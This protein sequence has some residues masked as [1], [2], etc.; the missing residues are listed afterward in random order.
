MSAIYPLWGLKPP[1]LSDL[2]MSQECQEQKGPAEMK[3]TFLKHIGSIKRPGNGKRPTGT[4]RR[5][6]AATGLHRGRQRPDPPAQVPLLT[7]VINHGA[8]Y[9][10]CYGLAS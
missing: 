1:A 5:Y 4:A 8:G 2:A 9:T 3:G 6:L 7:L 10:D